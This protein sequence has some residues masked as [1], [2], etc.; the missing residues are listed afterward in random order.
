MKIQEIFIKEIAS[1]EEMRKY[2]DSEENL[3]KCS[4]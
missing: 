1:Q 4:L 2:F 3:A